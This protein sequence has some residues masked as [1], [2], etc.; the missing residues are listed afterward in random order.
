MPFERGGVAT[1]LSSFGSSSFLEEPSC[2]GGQG[3][4]ASF[5]KL[6]A[7]CG[8]RPEKSGALELLGDG[9]L[10][11]VG[12]LGW[13]I[14]VVAAAA[15]LPAGAASGGRRKAAA[16]TSGSGVAA[17]SGASGAPTPFD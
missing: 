7:I 13:A 4:P 3:T 8:E 15:D 11:R 1:T 10:G 17:S 6:A 5:A 9:G 16:S 12:S 2:F 14:R